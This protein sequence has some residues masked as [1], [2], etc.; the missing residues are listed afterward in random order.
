MDIEE[1][2]KKNPFDVLFLPSQGF[3]YENQKNRLNV[4]LLTGKDEL[5]LTNPMLSEIGEAVDI[6]LK[7]SILDKDIEFDN[8]LLVD[9]QAISIFLKI[10]SYG[11]TVEFLT[12]CPNSSCNKTGKTSF[13]L[14]ELKAKDIIEL[15]DEEGNYMFILPKMKLKSPQNPEKK[16]P[17]IVKFKPLRVIDE[18][19]MLKES[20]KQKLSEISNDI[21]LRYKHQIT[22]I[23]GN[24]DKVYIDKVV[25]SIPISDSVALREYIQKVE[26]GIENEIIL[27]CE[28]CR[29]RLW[30]EIFLCMYYGKGIT[31]EDSYNMS[32]SER[33]WMINRIIEEIEKKNKAEEEAYN[34]AKS[35][36]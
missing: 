9:K 31:R 5:L 35:K 14:S 24:K 6:V 29:S 32:V 28:H 23:N 27:Q 11:S 3:F 4:K 16:I 12:N 20:K 19:N 2:Y 8:L 7:A 36:K 13:D 18:K 1:I 10:N 17:I 30:E 15:P 21:I 34:K 26:P 33:K 25:K 22:S